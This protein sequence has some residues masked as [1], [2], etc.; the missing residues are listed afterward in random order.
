MVFTAIPW[1]DNLLERHPEDA[2]CDRVVDIFH[3]V[4]EDE[5]GNRWMGRKT[6]DRK[7]IE[8]AVMVV[9][10]A[11]DSG[12]LDP[13]VGHPISPAYGSKAYQDNIVECEA[14]LDMLDRESEEFWGPRMCFNRGMR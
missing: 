9:Q 7:D 12:K 11:I 10:A 3:V 8:K 2:T 13:T 5:D 6:I 1:A 14:E 4:V